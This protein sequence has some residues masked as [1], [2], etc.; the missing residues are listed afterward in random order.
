MSR[1]ILTA[2]IAIALA[3]GCASRNYYEGMRMK[4]E[5]DCGKLQGA[6][7]DACLKQSGTTYD[8]YQRQMKD[9]EQGK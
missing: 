1:A 2:M 4:Q 8:E 9:R 7:R 6:E 5:A 3:A